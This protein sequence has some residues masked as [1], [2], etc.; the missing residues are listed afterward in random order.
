MK[1]NI[2]PFVTWVGGKRQLLKRIKERIP[3]N[4]DSYYE[5]FVGGGALF[6]ELQNSKTVINDSSIE[7]TETYITIRDNP[8][9]LMSLLDEHENNHQ[10]SPSEYF[11]S[12]RALDRQD[13]WEH[14]TALEKTARFIYL[15]KSCFNGMY[16]V[17][18]KGYYNVP[19]GKKDKINTYS[20]DNILI[21][22]AYLKSGQVKIINGDFE[23]AVKTAKKGDFIFF[24]PPYD[25]IKKDTFDRYTKDGFGVEGQ[26]RLSDVAHKLDKRGCY[27]MITNHN[28][29]LIN[30]LY[31][32]FN[33]DVV[34][35]KRM[36]NSDASNR[37]GIEV[38]MYNYDLEETE[39][40]KY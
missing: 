30:E 21:L 6:I 17:N 19:F 15:N 9:E 34:S 26:R 4:F 32:D 25:I 2:Q 36:I 37:K 18:K 38:I 3:K 22:S 7:L 8:I 23:N 5:P 24:D 10:K 31:F 12:I 1:Y 11:H 14:K 28:T 29:P 33:I 13:N 35:V 27:V 40:R 16:R 39:W 20:R